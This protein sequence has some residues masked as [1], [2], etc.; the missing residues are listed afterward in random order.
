MAIIKTNMDSAI[1]MVMIRPFICFSF[2]RAA[3]KAAAQTFY[4]NYRPTKLFEAYM[5]IYT[6]C[7]LL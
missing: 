1:S 7:K 4:L 3:A 2:T 6:A 5:Y